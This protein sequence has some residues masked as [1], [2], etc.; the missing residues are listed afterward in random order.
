MRV[1]LEVVD[2]STLAHALSHLIFASPLFHYFKRELRIRGL[3]GPGYHYIRPD[4]HAIKI[5]VN[6]RGC[7]VRTGQNNA[8]SR[9]LSAVLMNRLVPHMPSP[10]LFSMLCPNALHKKHELVR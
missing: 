6:L 3:L 8:I 2:L 7:T 9:K 1:R 10:V 5:L 4:A